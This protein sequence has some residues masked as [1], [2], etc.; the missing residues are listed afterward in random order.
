MP[1]VTPEQIERAKQMDLLTYLQYYEPQELVH[2]SGNVYRTR[3]HDSLKISNGKWCWWSRGIGG[4]SALDY[5][6]KVRGLSLPEAVVQ[7]GGQTA[8]LLPVPS[9]EPASAGP[10]KLL[11]P[12]KNENNDRVIVYL[13]GRG[14]KRDIID[15]CIQTKRL[16]ESRCYHNA[17]FVGFDSQGVPRYASLRGTSRRRFM[18]EANGSDKRLSFSIPARDNSSKLHL[19]ESAVDLMSYCTLEL[20]SGREWR[21]DF[22]LSLAGIYKPKQDISESTLPAAL[23]QFLKDFPQ[24][25]EIALH[26]DNDAAG[27]LAAKTIQTILPSHYIVFDEPPERGKDYNEYLRSTLKI[28]RIQERE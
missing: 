23:T 1:Y 5:L 14:I 10:R 13:A 8:A 17:V 16:Y 12:E 3:S 26:L 22:C 18:G 20:L 27:R 24:I 15:Y 2:F 28:R 9:K 7:I 25:S 19:F 6:V 4:R 11:L 21:Q